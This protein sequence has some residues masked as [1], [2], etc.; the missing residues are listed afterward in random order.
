MPSATSARSPAP[1]SRASM[2][3]EVGLEQEVAELVDEPGVGRAGERLVGHLVGLLDGVRHDRGDR[4][5]AVPRAVAAQAQR[6]APQLG[7]GA[8][9]RARLEL[10]ALRPRRALRLRQGQRPRVDVG[11]RHDGRGGVVRRRRARP[12]RPRRPPGALTS[13]EPPAP[14]S[15]RGPRAESLRIRRG[16][17]ATIMR[18]S[19]V[20]GGRR[21]ARARVGRTGA[22]GRRRGAAGCSRSRTRSSSRTGSGCPRTR[23]RRTC[24]SAPPR[25]A[26]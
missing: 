15:A 6:D 23:R 7:Q 20:G 12:A 5:L 24:S 17:S 11:R 26:T 10:L 25:A 1:S 21:R 13:A 22:G 19:L 2:R 9:G 18:T 14:S 3:Q 16:P 4:L 8:G